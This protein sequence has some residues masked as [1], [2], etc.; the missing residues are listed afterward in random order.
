[1][2]YKESVPQGGPPRFLISPKEWATRPPWLL[3][4][5]R[6]PTMWAACVVWE[7]ISSWTNNNESIRA[8]AKRCHLTLHSSQLNTTK[9]HDPELVTFA[10]RL[11][12]KQ[13]LS[14]EDAMTTRESGPLP[15][16]FET[17]GDRSV[18][19]PSDSGVCICHTV[20]TLCMR[21][22]GTRELEKGPA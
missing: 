10:C 9:Q 7:L 13:T 11:S 21:R 4:C 6:N 12:P 3:I 1:M 14:R 8:R 20:L 16:A 19:L 22:L 5:T 17:Q 15:P 2:E 18:C